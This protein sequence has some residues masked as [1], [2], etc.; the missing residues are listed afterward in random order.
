MVRYQT[1]LSDSPTIE[2]FCE[3]FQTHP[4]LADGYSVMVWDNSPT[5]LVDPQ[6]P[7]PFLYHHSKANLG[8]SGAYNG[9][10]KYAL[11]H[12]FPWMLLLDQ[13]T[14]VTAHFLATMLRHAHNLQ[15]RPEVAAIAP[16][17]SVR[18]SVVSPRR[19]R[20]NHHRA[21]P[22]GQLGVAPGEPFAINSG[23]VI[24]VESLREVGGYSSDFWLDYSDIYLFHQFHLRGM[25]TW[26]AADAKLEHDMS[27]MDYDRLMTPWRYRNY[28]F[29]ETAFNDLYKGR[30]E[31][32]AQTLRLAVRAVRQRHKYQSSEFSRI[33]YEQLLYRLRVPRAMRIAQWIAA[34]KERA[35]RAAAAENNRR[36]PSNEAA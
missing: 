8:T 1:A 3:A 5:S 29:A 18:N 23:C 35:A 30:L 12:D 17:V 25:S 13:D 33:T 14:A 16:T 34:G 31:N 22:D 27:I 2:G 9:A 21:Y 11:D 6:L 20:F 24:R 32:A 15:Q 4:E 10:M 7:F 26:R 36:T 28:S 19:Y